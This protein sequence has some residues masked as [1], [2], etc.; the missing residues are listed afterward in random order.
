MAFYRLRLQ[1]LQFRTVL[2]YSLGFQALVGMLD[3][4][5]ALRWNQTSAY[6]TEDRAA[7]PPFSTRYMSEGSV[8]YY[9]ARS[10]IGRSV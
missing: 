6:V 3:V 10:K 1:H 7:R 8:W 9:P 2:I 4:I 5:V